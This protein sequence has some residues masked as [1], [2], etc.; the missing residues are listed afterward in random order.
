MSK[1][2]ELKNTELEFKAFLY[3]YKKLSPTGL[4]QCDEKSSWISDGASNRLGNIPS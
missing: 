2:Q 4:E 3:V 1:T